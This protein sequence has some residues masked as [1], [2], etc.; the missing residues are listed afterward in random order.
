[1]S[2]PLSLHPTAAP[3]APPSRLAF[4]AAALGLA[5]AAAALAGWAP[6]EFSIVTVFLFAGPHNWLE[7]RYFLTRLPARWGRLRGFFLAAFAGMIGLTVSFIV[8][9]YLAWVGTLAPADWGLSLAIWDTTFLLW[10]AILA[11]LRSRQNPRREWGWVWPAC[12]VLIAV[13]WNW[14]LLWSRALVYLHPLMAFW[15]LD[16]ELKRSRPEWRPAFHAC[17]ALLPLFLA[18]LWWRLAGAAPLPGDDDLYRAIANHAGADILKG[19]SSHLLVATH[20]FL[21]MLHYGVWIVAIPLIG[22]RSAPW[23]LERV[24]LA[25]RGAPWSAGV[26][27]FLVTG[28][29]VVLV[30]WGCFAANYATTRTVYFTVAIFHVLAEVPFLLRSL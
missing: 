14:P 4:A 22:L 6:L 1:M 3:A 11:E 29:A 8:L 18:A 20:T 27:V 23:R 19:V 26:G 17:L 2:L 16:R 15:L 21:E 30:L 12:F 9:F 10:V 25:R 7:F 5:V 13:A 24:P 28:L